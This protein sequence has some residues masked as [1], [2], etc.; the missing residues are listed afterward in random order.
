MELLDGSVQTLLPLIGL[1]GKEFEREHRLVG[2]LAVGS[3][4]IADPHASPR[5]QESGAVEQR[6]ACGRRMCGGPLPLGR[7]LRPAQLRRAAPRWVAMGDQSRSN[8]GDWPVAGE[9]CRVAYRYRC[10]LCG[11]SVGLSSPRSVL[12]GWR[13]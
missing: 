4:E 9:S 8:P 12:V 2:V 10:W 1:G 3:E 6:A 13:R 11:L 7:G 5:L